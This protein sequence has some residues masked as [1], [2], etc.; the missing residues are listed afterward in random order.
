MKPRHELSS[1]DAIRLLS[2]AIWAVHHVE[3]EQEGLSP[4]CKDEGELILQKALYYLAFGDTDAA[5][6]LIDNY[7]EWQKTGIAAWPFGSGDAG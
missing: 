6:S 5:R 7:D 4:P 1:H 2:H 3:T